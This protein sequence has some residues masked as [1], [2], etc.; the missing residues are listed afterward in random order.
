MSQPNPESSKKLTLSVITPVYLSM[1]S[2]IPLYEKVTE[3]VSC[4]SD[5][6]DY[7]IIMVE[8]CGGDDSWEVIEQLASKDPHV[9]GVTL[10][11]NFGQH[12]AITAGLDLCNGDWV[13]VMDCDLQ[14]DPSAIAKLWQKAK[15]GYEVVNVRRQKRKDS[16]VKRVRSRVYHAILDWLSGMSYD[17]QVANYRMMSRKV[18]DAYITMRES[19]RAMGLQIHW[20]GFST[21]SIEI[22]HSVRH[23]GKSS[24]TLKKLIALAFDVA[25]SYSNKPLYISIAFG[26]IISL[27]SLVISLWFFIRFYLWHIPVTGWTSLMVSIWFLSGVIMANMGIL[28]IY[29]GKVYNETKSRPIYAIAKRVNC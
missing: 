23:E 8:D 3:T 13:V 9:K 22:P 21:D 17:P 15:E 20:L 29:I 16:L 7:E 6:T 5:F 11:R 4:L 14:D 18:V 28:G 26:L 2:L 10:S 1:N 24:Y 19:T 25:V 12:H 27:T